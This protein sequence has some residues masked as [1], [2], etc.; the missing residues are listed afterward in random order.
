MNELFIAGRGQ[1]PAQPAY[2]A[3]DD[4]R[5]GIEVKLPYVLEQHRAGYDLSRM[6]RQIFEETKFAWLEIDDMAVSG[7][8]P[9]HQID[10]QVGVLQYRLDERSPR[11]TAQGIHPCNELRE[12]EWL[13]EIVISAGVEPGN[14]IIDSIDPNDNEDI[15]FLA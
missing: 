14:A 3:F 1:F 5:V 7:N 13:G 6:T 2:M 15:L 10:L 4:V 9:R 12:G 11:A 8:R